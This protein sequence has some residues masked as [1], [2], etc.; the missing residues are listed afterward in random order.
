MMKRQNICISLLCATLMIPAASALSVSA[1]E[2][3]DPAVVYDGE[4]RELTLENVQGGDLFPEFKAMM[5]GDRVSQEI[6]VA[7]ERTDGPVTVYLTAGETVAEDLES[8]QNV[9]FTV[10]ADGQLISSGPLSEGQGEDLAGVKLFTFTEP[11]EKTLEVTLEVSEEAGNELM[12]AQAEVDWRFTVQDYGG[13]KTDGDAVQT[14]DHAGAFPWIAAAAA[15]LAAG[16]AA[17]AGKR[18]SNKR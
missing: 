15:S 8:F 9:I 6:R 16:T 3:G 7:A 17:A 2:A 1:A 11:G 18:R 12:D 14:G 5:P 4:E 13:G 10:R